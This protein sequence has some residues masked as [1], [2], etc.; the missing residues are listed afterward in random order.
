MK[1]LDWDE[2]SDNPV[3]FDISPQFQASEVLNFK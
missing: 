3:T 1:A 2:K